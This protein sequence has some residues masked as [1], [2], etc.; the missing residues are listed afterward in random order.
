MPD[1]GVDLS[2]HI[3]EFVQFI[4]RCLA[5]DNSDASLDL[6]RRGIEKP[7]MVCAIAQ[8]YRMLVVGKSPPFTAIRECPKLL[9]AISVVTEAHLMLPG[10]LVDFVAENRDSFREVR[11]RHV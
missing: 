11:R 1:V 10:Q 4:D 2:L 5:V 8:N 6:K 3:L 7:Q 9:K